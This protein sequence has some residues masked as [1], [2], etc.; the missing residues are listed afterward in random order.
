MFLIIILIVFLIFIYIN[1]FTFIEKFL[2]CDK[3]PSGPY[4]TNCTNIEF[5]NNILNAMCLS[6]KS[7][8]TFI[9]TK[10]DLE[11]CIKNYNDCDSINIDNVGNLICE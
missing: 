8:N 9:S 10:L 5:N 4:Q 1:E 6:N 7:D 3:V 2:I 11:K